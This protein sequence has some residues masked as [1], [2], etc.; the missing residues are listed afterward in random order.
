CCVVLPNLHKNHQFSR[1]TAKGM[2]FGLNLLAMLRFRF[3]FL[4]LALCPHIMLGQSDTIFKSF[5]LRQVEEGVQID[6]SIFSGATC[7]GIRVERSVDGSLFE[8]IYEFEGV[9]GSSIGE[10]FYNHIDTSPVSN[11]TSHYRLDA[12]LQGLYSDVRMIQYINYQE[13]GITQFPNP[14]HNNCYWYFNNPGMNELTC[15]IYDVLGKPVIYE[16]VVGTVW[17]PETY[18]IPQGLYYYYIFDKYKLLFSGK[19]LINKP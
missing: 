7:N 18:W 16:T 11:R 12:G 9:C 1:L 5:Q 6:F 15:T 17:Q 10:T 19:V 4:L 3:F 8:S 2:M 13:E 14:C